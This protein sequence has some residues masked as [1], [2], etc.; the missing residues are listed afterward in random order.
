MP[1]V[2]QSDKN[3]QRKQT[4]KVDTLGSKKLHGEKVR[5]MPVTLYHRRND[6]KN[7]FQ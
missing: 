7:R 6:K 2:V 4:N 5:E 1:T 3:L